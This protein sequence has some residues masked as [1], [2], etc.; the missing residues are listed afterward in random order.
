MEHLKAQQE[1]VNLGKT[2]VKELELDP[3]VDTLSKW[4]AHYA[5]EKIKSA[6]ELTGNKK[7]ATE[8][9]C[10]EIILKLWEQRW[11]IPNTKPFLRDFE[12][13]LETLEKLNPKNEVPFFY[14]PRIEFELEKENNEN[15]IDE[16]E[17][18][19]Q[20]ALRVDKLARSIIYDL[21]NQAVSGIE[22]SEE[23]GKLIKN[24]IDLVDYPDMRI[25]RI[26]SDYNKSKESQ[27]DDD[28]DE[29]KERIEEIQKRINDLEEFTSMKDS[30]LDRYKKELSEIEK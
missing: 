21:L 2:I 12:P 27:K 15:A 6:E 19:F 5:A 16:K 20:T 7:S 13:L 18:Y 1:I 10:I 22:L 14:S 3:G 28:Y 24:A 9:E 8:K 25:I 30:L 23:R 4:M 29:K 17:N 26:T 11:S